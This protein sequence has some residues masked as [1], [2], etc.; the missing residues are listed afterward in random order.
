MELFDNLMDSIAEQSYGVVD[1]F[2]TSEEISALVVTLRERHSAGSFK[3][4]GIGQG[5]DQHVQAQIRGDQILWLDEHSTVVVEQVY[6]QKINTLIQCLNRS[7]YLGLK[8]FELHYALYPIGT[9]YKRH[10]DRFKTDSHRKI[11]IICYLNEDWQAADGGELVIY[12]P[13]NQ[14]IKIAPFGG[15]LVCFEADLLEHEVLP[16]THERLSLTGWLRT[17]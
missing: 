15:R 4:A 14:P 1:F 17:Y 6:F 2:L 5:N 3:K 13:G 12:L 16:A 8:D 9:F 11:S 7:C 10:L